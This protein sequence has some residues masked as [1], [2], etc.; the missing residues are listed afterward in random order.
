MFDMGPYYL[1]AL[2]NLL[3]PV[4][5]VTGS[6]QISF[7]ERTATSKEK[8]GLKIKVDVPTHV[9]G[10]MDF[11]NGAV[12]TIIT[13]F[14]IWAHHVPLIEIHGTEGSLSVPDPNNFGGKVLLRR[15][16][17]KDWRELE[18]THSDEVG[19]GIGV[20]DMAYAIRSG[21]P[22]RVSG[23]LAYHV[24]DLMQSF[25]DASSQ[26]KHINIA[27]TVEQPAALPV[28]LAKGTLDS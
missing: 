22:N 2:V 15:W 21:R 11:A 1:T 6:A 27:S 18:H 19:R 3:G 4:R 26:G 17:E 24:L 9:A 7:P 23:Q 8:Y 13:S 28:G 20:A 16:D 5:R 25:H 12:G 10:I 14:D